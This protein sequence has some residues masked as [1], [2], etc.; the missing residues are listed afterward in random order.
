MIQLPEEYTFTVEVIDTWDMT[1]TPQE[2][3]F[4]GQCRVDMPGKPYIA[5]RIRKVS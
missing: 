1:I 3:V 5:L 2:G 4:Q